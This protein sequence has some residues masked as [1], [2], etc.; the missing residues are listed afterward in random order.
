MM[1]TATIPLQSSPERKRRPAKARGVYEKAPG[2]WYIRYI[3]ATGRLRREKAGSKGDAIDL[4]RKRKSE[5]LRG[6]KLPEK[7]RRRTVHFAELC[8]DFKV[9]AVANNEG[10]VNDGY[11][12]AQLKSAFGE[13]PADS[14]PIETFRNWFAQQDWADG[15]YNRTRTVLFSIYRL[16]IENRKVEANPARLL[17][18]RKVD[19]SRVRFLNQFEPLPT[20]VDYLKPVKTEEARL[21]AVIEHDYAEHMEEFDVAINTGMRR[22]EQYTRCDWSSVDLARKNLHVPQSKNG[23]G[24][25][26]PLN[27][28]ARA[29]FQRLLDRQIGDGPIP[30]T[31]KGAIFVGKGAE[32]LLGPKHWFGHAVQKAGI[33]HFTWHDLRHTF[34]SRLVMADVDIRTVAEL[35]GHKTLAMTMRYTHLA[36]EHKLVA[37]ERLSR[38]NS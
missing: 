11:R 33:Q 18:R 32:R 25:H 37:V 24:R 14:I 21:R 10:Y 17:K 27:P 35:L 20:E 7:L 19:D 28:E 15:T 8:D 34:A 9:Y 5:A 22:K 29:A 2:D 6:K 12:I 31:A 4:Y 3:D 23:L 26:I 38:Y 1:S 13:R 30:I 16:A 36:P